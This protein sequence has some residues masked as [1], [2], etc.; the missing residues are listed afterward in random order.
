MALS[1]EDKAEI[2]ALI[3]AATT[4]AA[5]ATPAPTPPPTTTDIAPAQAAPVEGGKSIAELIAEGVQAGLASHTSTQESNLGKSLWDERISELT[6][7]NPELAE[8]L[9]GEDDWGNKRMDQLNQDKDF[10]TRMTKLQGLTQRFAN[11]QMTDASTSTQRPVVS[12]KVQEQADKT[13]TRYKEIEDKMNAG[14]MS[15]EAASAAFFDVFDEEVLAQ[16]G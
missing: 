11:A 8:Y 5:P 9:D 15:P 4:T 6:T 2:A 3:T 13:G 14:E 7:R 1:A 12:K 10:A 16:M